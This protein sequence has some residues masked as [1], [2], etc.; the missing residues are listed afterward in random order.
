MID[1]TVT[2]MLIAVIVA[3]IATTLCSLMS[4][5]VL[6]QAAQHW[7]RMKDEAEATLA[8]V[9]AWSNRIAAQ[10]ALAGLIASKK[11]RAP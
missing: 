5:W 11:K 6:V 4:V 10:H 7:Q 9:M 8:S 3:G 1:P 2:T